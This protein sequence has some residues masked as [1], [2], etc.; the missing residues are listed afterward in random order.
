[1]SP[2]LFTAIR[3]AAQHAF[4]VRDFDTALSLAMILEPIRQQGE[5]RLQNLDVRESRSVPDDSQRSPFN[6]T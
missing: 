2:A 5:E 1:M 3:D 6:R 4:T